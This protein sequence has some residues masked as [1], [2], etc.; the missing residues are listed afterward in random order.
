MN[1]YGQHTLKALSYWI[2]PEQKNFFRISY[3]KQSF[4]PKLQK[5]IQTVYLQDNLD[6]DKLEKNAS[7][8]SLLKFVP[9]EKILFQKKQKLNDICD[10]PSHQGI[11]V[12]IANDFSFPNIS[13]KDVDLA[14]WL[15]DIQKN[16]QN[17]NQKQSKKSILILDRIQDP[18]NLGAILR[19]AEA[20]SIKGLILA[21]KESCPLS[22]IVHHV[23]TG[24]SLIL[25]IKWVSNLAQTIKILK[26]KNYWVVSADING[27]PLEDFSVG[28]N[29]GPFAL[30]VGSEGMGIKPLL[31]KESDYRFK[32]SMSGFTT[33][34][35]A[36][37]SAGI[38]MQHFKT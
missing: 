8:S 5:A 34:L 4:L 9:R 38:F 16:K 31:L 33:S 25:P 15:Y 32:I 11:I 28:K 21:K 22:S 27:S 36:S 12:K 19:S 10:T 26:K 6:T 20:L 29:D 24:A 18:H 17:E 1:L 23:S 14:S 7:I 13:H 37:V 3:Q 35:N 30:I 2:N